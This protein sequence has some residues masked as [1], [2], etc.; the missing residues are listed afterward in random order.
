MLDF[1]TWPLGQDDV[2]LDGVYLHPLLLEPRHALLEP[3]LGALDLQ[4]HPA[5]VGLDV[6]AA[7]IGDDVEVLD[8][9][10]DHRLLYQLGGKGQPH[11]HP[12]H[13]LHRPLSLARA[14][15]YRPPAIAG[16]M[17]TSSPCFSVVLA[18]SRNRMSSWL[19]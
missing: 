19:T 4:H 11:A 13:A 5:V 7:D 15:H 14:W 10:I 6:R 17:E 2:A 18:P 3:L 8:E 12:G 16:T 1:K 9:V